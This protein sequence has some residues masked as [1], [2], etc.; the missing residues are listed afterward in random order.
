MDEGLD[1]RREAE[2]RGEQ[3]R[4][5]GAA[6]RCVVAGRLEFAGQKAHSWLRRADLFLRCGQQRRAGRGAA[7]GLR[8]RRHDADQHQPLARPQI[9]LYAG[10]IQQPLHAD[11][12]G[13]QLQRVDP[14]GRDRP[15]AAGG[16]PAAD[17][18]RRQRPAGDGA[19]V[20]EPAAGADDGQHP[21]Q[22]RSAAGKPRAADEPHART[23]RHSADGVCRGDG[24]VPGAAAG[25]SPAAAGDRGNVDPRAAG[26]GP[27]NGPSRAAVAGSTAAERPKRRA[28]A[29]A[30]RPLRAA[31][32]GC[33]GELV[34][35]A[36]GSDS[37]DVADEST[38]SA[39]RTF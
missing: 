16:E 1:G 12:P 6:G 23:L 29:R 17:V 33:Y 32:R 28:V 11:R 26:P 36:R 35:G 20:E 25:L 38:T 31:G 4:Q 34:A 9:R 14:L 27:A 24:H 21:A 7:S 19:V 18:H 5:A 15:A 30:S 10:A 37:A 39:F 13:R 2:G 3:V 22:V 8:L